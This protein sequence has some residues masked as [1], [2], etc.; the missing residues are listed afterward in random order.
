MIDEPGEPGGATG[1]QGP[2]RDRARPAGVAPPAATHPPGRAP[3]IRHRM[4]LVTWLGAWAVISLILWALQ[5]VMGSWP[6]LARTFVLSGLMVVTLTWGVLPALS[7]VF[8]RWLTG[9][10]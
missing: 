4:A 6:L 5:P 10:R 9:G 2:A 7:R 1:A 8:R 3:P